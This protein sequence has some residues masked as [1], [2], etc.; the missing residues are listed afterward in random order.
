MVLRVLN[1]CSTLLKKVQH[2][3]KTESDPR[4]LMEKKG[5]VLWEKICWQILKKMFMGLRTK[6]ARSEKMYI[7]GFYKKNHGFR[8]N[9]RMFG[10]MF[11]VLKN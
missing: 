6:F 4:R 8:K 10:K 9:I 11:I 3:T 1:K 5:S 7:C 2:T